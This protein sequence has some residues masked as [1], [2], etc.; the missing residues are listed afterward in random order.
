[1]EQIP[2]GV[3]TQEFRE[4]AVKLVEVEGLSSREAARRLSIPPGSLKNWVH[5]ARAGK[6]KE[7]G[8][9]HEAAHGSGAGIGQDEKGTG[10]GQAG[11][12]SA[13][14][15][16]DL[17]REGVAVK[18]GQIEA[19]RQHY[20][21]AAL[22]RLLDV[23]E[24]GYHAW[25]KRP[26][27]ARARQ[28]AR[29]EMEIRAAHQRTRETRNGSRPSFPI[30][31]FGWAFTASSGSAKS[32]DCAAARRGNSRRPR[33][34]KHT[35]PVAPNVLDRQFAVAAPNRAWLTD[36]TSI[37]TDEGWL[38]LA[39]VKDLFSGE[40]VGYAISERMTKALVMQALFRACATKR[41]LE[42]ADS[43]FRPRQ[44]ILRP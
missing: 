2:R 38:Y 6:L 23:S 34:G 19:L 17:L 21:A 42:G 41:P 33:T 18:Y 35:L 44:P 4:Q 29:L 9:A 24:S 10:R 37:A 26:P 39:G 30:M 14:N 31:A 3:Y 32:W 22:C 5:A 36:I 28:E 1:M 8:K 27:S 40:V 43:S 13:K 11:A 12:R 7:V 15:V 20:P 16:C 25:R